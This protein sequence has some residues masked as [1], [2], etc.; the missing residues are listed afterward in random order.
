MQKETSTSTRTVNVFEKLFFNLILLGILYFAVFSSELTKALAPCIPLTIST[1]SASIM[2]IAIL[3]LSLYSLGNSIENI[4]IKLGPFELDGKSLMA[5]FEKIHIWSRINKVSWGIAII[6]IVACVYLGFLPKSPFFINNP[7]P[8]LLDFTIQFQGGRIISVQA[9]GA[10]DVFSNEIV[11]VE[12][13]V[14][15]SAKVACDWMKITGALGDAE[16]CATRYSSPQGMIRDALTVLASSTCST[17]TVF[18][19]FSINVSSQTP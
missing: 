6:L 13:N 4:K 9:G 2:I 14:V 7:P 1:V 12:A 16:G 10:I 5:V 17:G 11:I 19:G 8:N 3:H 18:R 15:E